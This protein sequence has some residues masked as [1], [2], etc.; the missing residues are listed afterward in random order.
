MLLASV[1]LWLRQSHRTIIHCAKAFL[2][3]K[4]MF[5]LLLR[6]MS[7]YPWTLR[8]AR[9]TTLSIVFQFFLH[10][11]QASPSIYSN[12]SIISA[13]KEVRASFPVGFWDLWSLGAVL[14]LPL[15]A[16]QPANRCFFMRNSG[17]WSSLLHPLILLPWVLLREVQRS[18]EASTWLYCT[19]LP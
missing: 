13:L 6:L 7:H 10:P 12:L 1:A 9:L 3:I 2:L 16:P 8:N 5:C 17:S 15:A 14:K 11:S 18:P 19:L 4:F